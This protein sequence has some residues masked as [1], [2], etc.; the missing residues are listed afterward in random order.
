MDFPEALRD[1]A[2]WSVAISA[3]AFFVS[4]YAVLHARSS[5]RSAKISASAAKEQLRL[6]HGKALSDIARWD[7][8]ELPEPENQHPDQPRRKGILTNI[9]KEV[10][11]NVRVTWTGQ[12]LG[13]RPKSVHA[14]D[15]INVTRWWDG[16][17]PLF[18]KVIV[19]W[20]RPDGLS[21]EDQVQVIPHVR[22]G[23]LE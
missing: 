17:D 10:A 3:A 21:E 16:H 11:V 23:L 5:S 4:A 15:S 20:N 12:A 9:G 13:M 8:K 14:G 1:P 2:W 18:D 22:P 7:F 19:T 6:E